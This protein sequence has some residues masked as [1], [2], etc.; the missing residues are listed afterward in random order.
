MKLFATGLLL[1]LIGIGV[2]IGLAIHPYHGADSCT[3]DTDD[4]E[5][6]YT[7]VVYTT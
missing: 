5:V 4:T 3:S 7:P 1:V 2:L 6:D